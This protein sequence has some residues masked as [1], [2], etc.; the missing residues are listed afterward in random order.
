MS[1]SLSRLESEFRI[2][3]KSENLICGF[4]KV[5]RN[6]VGEAVSDFVCIHC[7]TCG[8]T[9]LRRDVGKVVIR[10]KNRESYTTTQD[11]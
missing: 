7:V 1:A 5:R 6:S 10:G 11:I 2:G 3:R 8:Q 4:A 9:R